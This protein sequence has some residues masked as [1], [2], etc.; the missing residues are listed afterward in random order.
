MLSRFRNNKYNREKKGCFLKNGAAMLEQLI[1]S[2][3]GSCN[4]IRM[5]SERDLNKATND[6][7]WDGMIHRD[8]NS[9]LYKGVH[10]ECQILV[11][12]FEADSSSYMDPLELIAN[13][14]AIASNMSKHKNVLKLLG[15]CLETELPTLIY[16]FPTK[17]NLSHHIYGDGESLP[18]PIRL[19][20]AI[21]VAGAVAYLHYGMPK[22]I[23]HQDIKTGHIF[24]DQDYVAKLSE[25]RTSVPIPFGKTH[26]DVEVITG[27]HGCLAPE[28]A[29]SGR[30][31][32][33]SDVH[34][35]G[36][37]LCEIFAGKRW[38]DLLNWSMENDNNAG[39]SSYNDL[40]FTESENLCK[41]YLEAEVLEEENKKQVVECAKL[42]GRCLK[43]NPDER[44]IMTEVAQSLRV[45]KSL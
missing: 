20:I 29:I 32:E 42:I 14:L 8:W 38:S 15:C 13:E 36:V 6:Y 35:F 5:Y 3:D 17:G 31:S 43:T 37:L 23:I 34:S 2:F 1:H 27:T 25:F 12:K 26:V 22:M 19:K 39:S 24:I 11:K 4:P 18:W 7:G 9:R 33:K 41:T 40:E 16:E 10:E 45:I 44:P 28:Y 30:T 21:E